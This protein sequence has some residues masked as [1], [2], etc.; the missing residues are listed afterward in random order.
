MGKM[1]KRDKTLERKGRIAN[2]KLKYYWN[3]IEVVKEKIKNLHII[4]YGDY[5]EQYIDAFTAYRLVG[6]E[7]WQVT[8]YGLECLEYEAQDEYHSFIEDLE[9]R[10]YCVRW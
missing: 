9:C 6:F 2:I 10:G 1:T 3:K 5:W 7:D 8:P 4:E